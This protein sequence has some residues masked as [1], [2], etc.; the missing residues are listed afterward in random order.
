MTRV[1]R[2]A[3]VR[4]SASCMYQLVADIEAYPQFLPWCANATIHKSSAHE[5][6]ATLGL[7]KGPIRKAFST[8]NTLNPEERIELHLLNGPFKSLQGEWRFTQLG[9]DGSRVQLDLEF[10]FSSRLLAMTVGPVF[11][12]IANTMVQAFCDRAGVLYA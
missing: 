3:L 8:R 12:E 10:E 11:N 1:S 5:V 2:N 7:A 4:Y 6:E 9:E